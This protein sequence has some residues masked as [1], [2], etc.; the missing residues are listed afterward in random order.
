MHYYDTVG[1]NDV[2]Q[3]TQAAKSQE[4]TILDLFNQYP[5][6][7]FTPFEVL[8]RTNLKCIN[9]VRRA[10]TNLTKQGYLRKTAV[11][12]KG[13]FGHPNRTWKLN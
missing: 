10:I 8:R 9:S 1:V 13:D 6:D 7:Y 12:E 2:P 5:N 4:D 11:L 3:R